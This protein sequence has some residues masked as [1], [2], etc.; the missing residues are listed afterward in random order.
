MLSNVVDKTCSRQSEQ[1][2]CS[3]TDTGKCESESNSLS[4]HQLA[5]TL[6]FYIIIAT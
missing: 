4:E 2:I 3:H 1:P 5:R 6:A